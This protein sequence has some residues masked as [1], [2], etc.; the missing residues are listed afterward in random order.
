MLPVFT[1]N[2]LYRYINTK[3][4][5]LLAET[6][7]IELLRQFIPH[8]FRMHLTRLLWR[9]DG[10]KTSIPQLYIIVLSQL[11]LA[12][13]L[14]FNCSLPR[15]IIKNLSFSTYECDVSKERIYDIVGTSWTSNFHQENTQPLPK[16]FTLNYYTQRYST[17]ECD[18]RAVSFAK[19]ATQYLIR[20]HSEET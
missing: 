16:G 4:D 19:L 9:Q 14:G 12:L 7:T 5:S 3:L 15:Q 13:L 2:D 6:L 11:I 8:V 20:R 17:I 1:L 10:L 18:P